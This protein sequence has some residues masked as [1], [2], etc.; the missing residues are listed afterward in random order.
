MAHR[1]FIVLVLMLTVVVFNCATN[2]QQK[3]T[4]NPTPSRA[5][6]DD[7]IARV[8]SSWPEVSA[9]LLI[10][11]AQ[12][13]LISDK[14]RKIA[15]LEEAYHRGSDAQ[16][17]L[18]MKRWTGLVDTA[19]GQL[20]AA[21]DLELDELSIKTRAVRTMSSLDAI[22]S[23]E[24]F[25]QIPKLKLPPL[26]CADDLGYEVSG[27]YQTLKEVQQKSFTPKELSEGNGLRFIQPYISNIES[28][29]QVA[30]VV[31]LIVDSNL[32]SS[33]INVALS[34]L[35]SALKGVQ[36]DP[37]SFA[38]S[39]TSGGLANSLQNLIKKSRDNE[40]ASTPLL[41]AFRVY[42][43]RELSVQCPDL[44]VGNEQKNR[45]QVEFS[46]VNKWFVSPISEDE[47][48]A[49]IGERSNETQFWA[50]PESRSFLMR[51]KRLRF[52]T[53]QT[54]L[55]EEERNNDD[56][57]LELR[58]LLMDLG[59]WTGSGDAESEVFHEKCNLY[60]ALYSLSPNNALRT[61]VLL[62]FAGYL[63]V[64]SMQESSCIEWLL[65]G[66]NLLKRT[67]TL[68]PERLKII[69]VFNTSTT[70]ALQLYS[71]FDELITANQQQYVIR[72]TANR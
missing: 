18:R 5:E 54:A 25:V 24:L 69:N 34:T 14:K 6:I 11:I 17:K 29:A 37:K 22:R 56:W 16:K 48:K 10:R 30:P 13:K 62:A 67:R 35:V 33:E 47:L 1:C 3:L 58:Q 44:R 50:S 7:F 27:F 68:G 53:G 41:N 60:D 40:V 43:L 71:Q 4:R 51:V 39:L 32:T 49:R 64:A 19:S 52:G 15:L 28:P 42:F 8:S 36:D 45:L 9:D 59:Q 46:R 65:H 61:E 26:S 66:H 21:Y 63:R 57:Q 70:Q 23:R 55:T 2:A 31:S 20:S 38:L 72:P 12:S